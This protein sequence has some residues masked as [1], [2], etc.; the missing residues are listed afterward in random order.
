MVTSK[1]VGEE[2]ASGKGTQGTSNFIPC[3]LNRHLASIKVLYVEETSKLSI[4]A[5]LLYS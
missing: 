5:R 3:M 1:G 2:M 4:L